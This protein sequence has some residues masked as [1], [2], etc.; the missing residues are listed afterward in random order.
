MMPFTM[1]GTPAAST[2]SRSSSTDLLPAGGVRFF[3]KGRPAASTSIATAK[4]LA[5]FT[6]AIFSRTVSMFHGFTVGMPR[7]P[8]FFTAAVAATITSGFVPSP[9]NAAMPCSAHAD[10][11]MSL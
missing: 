4:A 11:R 8:A 10:T 1:N 5:S 7:P 6:S 3:R 2:I 9:V